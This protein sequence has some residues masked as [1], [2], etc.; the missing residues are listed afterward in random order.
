M[1]LSLGKPAT[2]G[3]GFNFLSKV[4]EGKFVQYPD[5]TLYQEIIYLKHWFKGKYAVENVISYYDPLIAPQEINKHYF[6]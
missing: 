2:A 5:M 1:A 3:V 4:Q 6:I